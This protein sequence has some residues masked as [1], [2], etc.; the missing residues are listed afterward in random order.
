MSDI[1][2]GKVVARML[3]EEGVEYLFTLCGGHID[4]ILQGCLDEGIRVIDTRHE[5]AAI[6]MAEGWAWMTG[7]PGVAAITAGPGITNSVTGLWNATGKG[8]PVIVFG[9]KSSLRELDKGSLQDLDSLSLAK[10][11]TKW[12]R[13]CYE[14]PR[15]GEYVGMA[16]RQAMGGRPGAAYLEFPQ[17]VLWGRLEE[18]EIDC[19]ENYRT[20][21]RPQA[22]PALVE[23]ALALLLSA[24]RPLIV[25]GAGVWLSRAA[26]E[27]RE[28]IEL[29]G[30]PLSGGPLTWVQ[31]DQAYLP[32]DHPLNLGIGVGIKRADVVM[33]V[34]A[35]IDFR[36]GFGS[37]SVFDGDSKWIQIDIDPTEIGQNRAIDVGIVGDCR[38]VLGQMISAARETCA[39]RE[40]LPWIAEVQEET[41]ALWKEKEAVMNSDSVPIH[42]ARLCRE[43]SDFIDRDATVIMDGGDISHSGYRYIKTWLPGHMTSIFPTGTLGI[44]P[45]YA[46]AARLARPGKQVLLLSGDGAFGLN[47]MEFDTMIRHDLPVVCVIGN[48]ESWGAIRRVQE[49]VGSNRLIGTRLGYVRY[50]RMVE[51]MGGHGESVERP[52]DIRP[53]LERAFA[54]G[55]PACVNV[56]C[57]F[58]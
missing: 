55:L 44:G 57:A 21:S 17:D 25:A 11:V 37:S 20:A 32:A 43:I 58:V 46:I 15:I 47:G 30:I 6:M 27:L 28:F 3:R 23:D 31:R 49:R 54:S 16:F 4:P 7:K 2:G 52:E 38:A 51:A 36:L 29:T 56:R 10:T 39:G 13:A 42:P 1:N 41:A 53:A 8:A 33:L 9:G 50:E 45:S 19:P 35:R 5:Q 40:P 12:A 24:E 26:D 48:D 22:E 34:G 14:T 18:S